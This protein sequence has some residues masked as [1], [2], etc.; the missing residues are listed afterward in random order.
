MYKQ[1]FWVMN[2]LSVSSATLTC[3]ENPMDRGAWLATVHGVERVGRNLVTKP[4]PLQPLQVTEDIRRHIKMPLYEF[5][6]KIK[7]RLTWNWFVWR[8][9]SFQ[10]HCSEETSALDVLKFLFRTNFSEIVSMFSWPLKY[11]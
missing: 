8:A 4:S 2:I 7:F 5:T 3:L 1:V 11:S 10:K 6:F 9:K